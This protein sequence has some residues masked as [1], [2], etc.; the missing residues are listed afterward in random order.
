VVKKEGGVQEQDKEEQVWSSEFE[1]R[2]S[3]ASMK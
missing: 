1:V 2:R 3:G